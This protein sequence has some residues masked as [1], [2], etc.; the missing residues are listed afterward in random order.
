[1]IITSTPYRISFFGGGTDYPVFFK[2][3]AG[4]V[5]AAS[6]NRYCY[7]SCRFYPPFFEHRHR[8]VWSRI[9]LVQDTADIQHPAVREAIRYLNI[10]EGLEIHHD[11]DLPARTGLGS[12]SAFAVGMLHALYALKGELVSKRKLAMEAIH[13]EQSILNE[14]VGIQDQITTAHGGFNLIE[15]DRNGGFQVRP[16]PLSAARKQALQEHLLLIYTG[17]ARTA[18]QVAE[19]QIASI[20]DKTSVLERMK[21]LVYE[22]TSILTGSGDIGEFGKLL[23]ETWELKRSISP[24]VSTPLIDDLYT[25]ARKAGATG[26]KLLGAGGGGFV[27]LFVEPQKRQ[28]VLDALKDFLMVPFEFESNGTHIV[29]YEPERYSQFARAMRGFV[30]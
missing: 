10:R 9:E 23:H 28:S 17:V 26:G 15:I 13:L 12:S 29:L 21:A 11:G 19:K 8:I 27:L 24:E 1:M 14:T 3:H 5:L 22:A 20:P 4:A 6:I 7:I 18:S 16:I 30:R 25:R 2:H